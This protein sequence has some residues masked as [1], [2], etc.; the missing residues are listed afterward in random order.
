LAL[1]PAQFAEPLHE[2]FANLAEAFR[3]RAFHSDDWRL[4]RALS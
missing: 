3:C 4:S 2:K 1:D